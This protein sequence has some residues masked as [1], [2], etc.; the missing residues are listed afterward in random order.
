MST[1]NFLYNT[2]SGAILAASTQRITA[3]SG[4]AVLSLSQSDT[5]AILAYA[6]PQWYLIQGSTPALVEQPHWVVTATASTSTTGQ[7]TISGTLAHPPSTLPSSATVSVAGGTIDATVSSSGTTSTTLQLHASV[8]SQPVTVTVSASGTVSGSTT[9]NSGTATTALQLDT[10]GST[11]TVQPTTKAYLRQTAFGLTADNLMA[12]LVLSLQNLALASSV[13][14]EVVLNKILPALTA[15]SYSPISLST[16]ESDA[17]TNWQSNVV[18]YQMALKD[19]L[20][21][22]GNAVPPYADMQA[23]A[24]NVQSALQTYAQWVGEIPHLS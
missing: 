8:A 17:M 9:I 4:E 20:D 22:S 24:P 19:L 14:S 16:A 13:A 7:Y 11:P 6:N 12:M 1:Y 2:S 21:A 10:S 5:T 23:Q 3:G 18:Q 15:S